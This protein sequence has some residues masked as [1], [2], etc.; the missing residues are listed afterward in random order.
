MPES[1][2]IKG[3][4]F[5]IRSDLAKTVSRGNKIIN[6]EI[7][8]NL[9]TDRNESFDVNFL[10]DTPSDINPDN[11]IY[12]AKLL[13]IKPLILE[14]GFDQWAINSDKKIHVTEITSSE[15]TLYSLLINPVYPISAADQE[16]VIG[17][18]DKIIARLKPKT[19]KN[20]QN[21]KDIIVIT[22]E[23]VWSGWLNDNMV[24]YILSNLFN[25]SSYCF[26]DKSGLWEMVLRGTWL[27]EK[28]EKINQLMFA[29]NVYFYRFRPKEERLDLVDENSKRQ[30][31]NNGYSR[32]INGLEGF[33]ISEIDIP[34]DLILSGSKY[35]KITERRINGLIKTELSFVD[36]KIGD[37]VLLGH[38]KLCDTRVMRQLTIINSGKYSKNVSFTVSHGQ[39]VEKGETIAVN[40]SIS[41]IIRGEEYLSPRSGSVDLSLRSKGYVIIWDKTEITYTNNFDIKS[42][43]TVKKAKDRLYV[44]TE[45]IEIPCEIANNKET[46]GFLVNN[47]KEGIPGKKILYVT[48]WNSKDIDAEALLNKN[49]CGLVFSTLDPLKYNMLQKDKP[50]LFEFLSIYV[51][52]GY[53]DERCKIF[54]K[55]MTNSD[56]SPITLSNGIISIAVS[57]NR[58]KLL[59]NSNDKLIKLYSFKAKNRYYRLVRKIDSNNIL[60]SDGRVNIES[61]ICNLLFIN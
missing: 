34:K 37:F 13:H 33:K 38:N 46:S 6:S 11:H 5:S 26:L 41:G 52:E 17:L 12:V 29:P 42:D 9:L 22:G 45:L 3:D 60:I 18:I 50:E 20:A 53:S 23:M 36:V 27:S 57:H 25:E 24:A 15:K 30:I 51:I 7:R 61:D 4:F 56:G 35:K 21:D 58:Y 40:K 47:I 28:I 2:R 49:F 19:I 44:N 39:I 55:I 8:R 59:N 16:F 1:F 31:I 48:D 32:Y 43:L 54:H 14:C 10:I